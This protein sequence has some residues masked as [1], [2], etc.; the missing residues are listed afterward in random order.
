VRPLNRA[1]AEDALFNGMPR[2][3]QRV[4]LSQMQTIHVDGAVPLTCQF[5]PELE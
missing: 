5:V 1:K 4:Q 2:P 3:W